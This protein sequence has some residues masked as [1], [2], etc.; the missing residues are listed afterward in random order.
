MSRWLSPLAV[1]FILCAQAIAQ[2][3]R[4]AAVCRVRSPD[5]GGYSAGSGTLI[6]VDDRVGFV[7]TAAH[8]IAGARGEPN[9]TFPDGTSYIG[10][11]PEWEV[12][13]Q[14]EISVKDKVVIIKKVGE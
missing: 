14:Y 4:E 6:A 5:G 7:L 1:A 9:V 3:G 10:G 2:S 13:A 11:T 8:V 12:S